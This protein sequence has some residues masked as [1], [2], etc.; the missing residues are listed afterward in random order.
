MEEQEGT[1]EL[2]A[3]IVLATLELL[4]SL[5]LCPG[6]FFEALVGHN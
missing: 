4:L 5:L 3:M 6:L 1:S 2:G